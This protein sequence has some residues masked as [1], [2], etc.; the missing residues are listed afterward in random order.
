MPLRL[1]VP[2]PYLIAGG[3]GQSDIAEGD[4]VDL[5]AEGDRE[6]IDGGNATGY[7]THKLPTLKGPQAGAAACG[8]SGV[9]SGEPVVA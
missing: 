7:C 5:F 8:P 4:R 6:S 3:A 9:G 2:K 1:D